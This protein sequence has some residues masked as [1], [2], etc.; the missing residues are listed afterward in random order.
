MDL[1]QTN[2]HPPFNITRASHIVLTSRDLTASREFYVEVLGLVVSD[3]D[4]ETIYLRGVEER[5][6]HSL[7]LKK[8]SGVPSCERIGFRVFL[9]EDLDKAKAHFDAQ[10]FKADWVDVPFQE[11]TLHVSDPMGTPLELCASMETRPRV[12]TMVRTHK[13]AAALRMD[14][15]QV[16]VPEIERN[17][18]FYTD[19]GFRVSDCIC[20]EGTDI[21]VGIF[22]YRKNNPHD[23]VFLNRSG[24]RYHHCGY[25]VY[26]M[27]SM[28]HACDVAGTIGLGECVEYGPG[29]HALGH[30]YYVY[31][32]DPDG[33]R[34]E[35]LL[36]AIQTGDIEDKPLRW[37]V[38]PEFTAEAW[39]LPPQ[40]SW[41]LEASPFVDV[42]VKV[43]EVEGEPMTLERYLGVKNS[44]FAAEENR[45]EL[46]PAFK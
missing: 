43:P 10:G 40:S 4:A 32:R 11:R 12:Q 15:Y 3:E 42:E 7:T 24:P 34:T 18:K 22:L 25:I 27:H 13:G 28:I 1:G 14:H 35:L 45:P 23:M 36:P 38:S 8:T 41:M 2:L 37:D 16:I 9:D 5:C 29:R 21:V 6:H 39:G 30:S 26:D 33:H 17:T 19:L 44:G 31:L 20:I 46:Q